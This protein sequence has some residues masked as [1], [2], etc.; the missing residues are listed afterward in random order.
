[1]IVGVG[2]IPRPPNSP[3]LTGVAASC[4]I[5]KLVMVNGYQ[6]GFPQGYHACGYFIGFEEAFAS[7]FSN[8]EFNA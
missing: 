1:M 4:T 5:P 7:H 3:P 8:S 6:R 2:N